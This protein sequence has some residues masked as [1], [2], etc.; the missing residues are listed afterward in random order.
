MRL[1]R[2]FGLSIGVSFLFLSGLLQRNP[3]LL[4]FIYRIVFMRCSR[5]LQRTFAANLSGRQVS[6]SAYNDSVFLLIA[7]SSKQKQTNKQ[8]RRVP[9]PSVDR[10]RLL[11]RCPRPSLGGRRRLVVCSKQSF[12]CACCDF[13]NLPCPLRYSVPCCQRSFFG[14]CLSSNSVGVQN[15]P[16]RAC[17]HSAGFPASKTKWCAC[18]CCCRKEI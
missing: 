12:K 2:R 5:H 6:F 9:H 10:P 4:R 14:D 7:S 16:L 3:S 11:S 15:N 18:E 8:N 13:L 17:F 1:I